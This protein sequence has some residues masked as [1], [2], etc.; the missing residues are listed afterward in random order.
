MGLCRARVHILWSAPWGL[1]TPPLK[2]RLWFWWNRAPQLQPWPQ[3]SQIWP[4]CQR[5]A[6][7]GEWHNY[8]WCFIS[9][10][11]WHDT[12]SLH[13]LENWNCITNLNSVMFLLIYSIS[14][15]VMD[16]I[17]STWVWRNQKML[18]ASS[19]S[20]AMPWVSKPHTHLPNWCKIIYF[21][22]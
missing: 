14:W 19:C 21:G 10:P 16:S 11:V 17:P 13:Y 20:T 9:L 5:P 4:L 22:E 15:T 1:H 6:S 12:C 7:R 2:L 18:T 3:L 8:C